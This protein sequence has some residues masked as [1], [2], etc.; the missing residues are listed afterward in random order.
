MATPDVRADGK[1]DVASW[2]P[3]VGAI[4]PKVREVRQLLGLSLQQLAG[5]SEVSAAAIHKVERGDMVPTI[6]TLLKLSAALGRPIG[7]FVDDA[8]WAGPVGVHVRAGERPAAPGDWAP[9]ASGVDAAAIALPGERLRGA[10]VW[11]EIEPGGGSGDARSVRTGEELVLVT[12]GV[13]A[14]DV[15]GER[16]RLEAG[17][18]LHFPA[19][20]P[21][22]WHNPGPET[23][24]A[25]WW[26]L[27]G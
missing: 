4:G 20:R 18:S 17:D 16:Y 26:L 22:S 15:A 23:T 24:T 10:G 9:A 6:T 25:V 21:H 27:R 13:L 1:A 2:E 5:R 7:F 14:V 12:A 19:D 8:D 11:A 3:I